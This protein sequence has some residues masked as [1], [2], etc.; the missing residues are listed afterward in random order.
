VYVLEKSVLFYSRR[1]DLTHESDV[2][3]SL[4]TQA[5]NFTHVS[6]SHDYTLVEQYTV[7]S[8]FGQKIRSKCHL[9]QFTRF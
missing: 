9:K 4:T 3:I 2:T 7:I 1:M 6:N 8:I 5:A